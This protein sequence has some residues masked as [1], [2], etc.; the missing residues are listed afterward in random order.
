[1]DWRLP[2][3][4]RIA[5]SGDASAYNYLLRGVRQFPRQAAFAAELR[6]FGFIDVSYEN[7]TLGIVAIHRGVKPP[8][9]ASTAHH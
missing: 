5:T 4:A 6:Q 7:L 2:L 1:M 9:Q 3:I 8:S